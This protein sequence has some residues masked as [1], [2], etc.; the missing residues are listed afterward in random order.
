MEKA[1]LS[2]IAKLAGVSKA[3]AGKVLN[4][5]RTQIRVSEE[6]RQRILAAA[7]QLHYQPNMAASI[8]AGGQSRIIG[9]MIDSRAADS[10]YRILAEIENEAGKHGY[11]LLIAQAHDDPEK[12][13]NSYHS[14]KQNGVDGIIS[15]AHDY[16]HLNCHLDTQLKDDPK[17]VYVGSSTEKQ[18]SSVDF[19]IGA[20]MA[21]AVEH[22]RGGGYHKPAL[23][24]N[25]RTFALSGEKRAESFTRCCPEG[26]I[27]KLDAD[28]TSVADMEAQCSR[29]IREEL[30]PGHFDA[31]IALNDYFAATMMKLLPD[32]GIRI[33]DDFGL[34]GWD[35]HMLGEF[36]PVKLTS[37]G[38]DK[39]DFAVAVL[40]NLL[41][42]IKGNPMPEKI[43]IPMKL[44]IRESSI[45]HNSK[46]KRKSK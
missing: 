12:I 5:G 33:P 25:L 7:E 38:S 15:F 2:D 23:I 39:K 46:T 28:E 17:I 19:D 20:G 36:L 29:L 18:V 41:N 4:G 8:L 9:V 21:A 14:L 16:S 27:L 40:K 37:V 43:M 1:K 35:N 34:I 3:A 26:Q 22:L 31:A 45:K 6:T 24:L 30:I 13:L 42:K 32:R 11:R 44:I 10:Q